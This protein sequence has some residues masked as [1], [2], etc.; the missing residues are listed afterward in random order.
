M[1]YFLYGAINEGIN[2]EDYKKATKGFNYH[3]NIGD[4]QKVNACVKLCNDDYRITHKC[5]DCETAIGQG[6]ANNKDLKEFETLLKNLKTVRGIK[7]VL[8][9]KNWWEET[10]TKL[11]VEYIKDIDIPQFLA[12]IEDNCLYKIE[13]YPKYY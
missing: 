1:C 9:S 12:N 4:M 10:N 2:S 13:M 5:C 3:F 8:L 11:Q 7:Y 6:N